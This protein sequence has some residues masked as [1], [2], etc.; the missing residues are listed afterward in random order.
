MARGSKERKAPAEK[1]KT[2]L[3][4]PEHPMEAKSLLYHLNALRRTLMLCVFAAAGGF[5]VIFLGF[6]KQLVTLV[7]GPLTEQGIKVIFTGVSEAFTAQTKLS[8]I[9]GIVIASPVLFAAL[10]FY[11]APG[12]HRKERLYLGTFVITASFLFGL[13]VWFAYRYVFF[14]AVNFFVYAGDGIAS[15][16]LSL[17]TYVNFLFGFLLPF[18]IMFELPIL[19][20]GLTRLGLVT[21]RELNRARKYVLFALAIIAAILTPP[22]VVSQVMLGLPMWALFEIGV[23]C[24]WLFRPRLKSGEIQA[25]RRRAAEG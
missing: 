25:A 9:V 22:D 20:V 13:G 21:T 15:P 7:T 14:L 24:S 3:D 1:F 4:R 18:G 17:E 10:W 23:F 12:L 5:L 19:V 6:S 2:W 11:I 16:M 8:L